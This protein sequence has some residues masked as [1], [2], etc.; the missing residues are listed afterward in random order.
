[1]VCTIFIQNVITNTQVLHHYAI[2]LHHHFFPFRSIFQLTSSSHRPDKQVSS[3]LFNIV[4]NLCKINKGTCSIL[5]QCLFS[6]SHENSNDLLWHLRL[7]HEPF[8]KSKGIFPLLSFAPKQ[9][10][11][12]LIFPMARQTRVPFSNH[13]CYQSF[14]SFTH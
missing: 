3:P 13:H 12:C 11:V 5:S 1:M 7:G 8:V 2:H 4:N 14:W 9:P 6:N 10:F